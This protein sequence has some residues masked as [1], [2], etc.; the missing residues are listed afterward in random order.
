MLIA[1]ERLYEVFRAA[2]GPKAGRHAR[3][4]SL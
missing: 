3:Q 1:A 4:R 2:L